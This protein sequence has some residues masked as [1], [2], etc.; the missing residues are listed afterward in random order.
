VLS[1]ASLVEVLR[2][3]AVS[4]ECGTAPLRLIG[5]RVEGA[6]DLR[7]TQV[8]RPLIAEC[9]YF[10]EPIDISGSQAPWLA[11]ND[12]FLPALTGYGARIEGDLDLSGST[13]SLAVDVFA[14]R[15]GGRFVLNGACLTARAGRFAINAP[16]AVIGGG[17]YCNNGFS[18][19]G[20]VNLFGASVGTTLEFAG[21]TLRTRNVTHCVPGA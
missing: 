3:S 17:M 21:A 18:S 15:V 13:V 20:G 9:C 11:L 12:C 8:V 2:D 16:E 7:H 19:R 14:V 6:L 1:A 10:S 5:A 4:R